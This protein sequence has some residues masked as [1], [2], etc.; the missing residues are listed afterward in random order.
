MTLRLDC[1]ALGQAVRA[2][3]RAN[4]PD[5]WDAAMLV[6]R[7]LRRESVGAD[8]V[9]AA[10][11]DRT[12]LQPL[13]ATGASEPPPWAHLQA[14]GFEGDS[15]NY[16]ALRNSDL[17]AV[18][19]HR[20]GIPITLA[21]LLIL[22]ARDRG[23]RAVGLNHPGHFL[24]RIDARLIDPFALVPLGPA[25]QAR[26]EA[27]PE[28]DPVA[29]ALRMFNNVKGAAVRSGEWHEVLAVLELQQALLPDAHV[30]QVPLLE[31]RAGAWERL[32]AADMAIE[33]CEQGLALLQTRNDP[34]WVGLPGDAGKH[35]QQRLENRLPAL[36]Q[37]PPTIHH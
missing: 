5:E 7:W 16:T 20:R 4:G 12:A 10:G 1:V 32:G 19:E 26:A 15:S 28:V 37:Q 25:E 27:A 8:A 33:A 2:A 17:L 11:I 21:V 9:P 31:E 18:I 6:C 14:L 3:D 29:L 36:R 23:H 13:L 22:L 30:Q 24:V 34:S 35:W